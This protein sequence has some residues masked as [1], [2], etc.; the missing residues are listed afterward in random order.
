MLIVSNNITG[1]GVDYGSGPYSVAFPAGA[2]TM[3][4]DVPIINN[5]ICDGDRT[6]DLDIDQSSLPSL[7]TVVN[8]SQAGVNIIDDE[9]KHIV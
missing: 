1:G 2:T 5:N 6:F 3:S 7:V 4:F 8:P 9:S